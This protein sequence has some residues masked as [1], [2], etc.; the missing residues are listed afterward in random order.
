MPSITVT[1][2]ITG[3]EDWYRD[4][5]KKDV[6]ENECREIEQQIKDTL[7]FGCGV[8]RHKAEVKAVFNP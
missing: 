1:I 7:L 3:I 6:Q 8:E 5:T 2:E 4:F